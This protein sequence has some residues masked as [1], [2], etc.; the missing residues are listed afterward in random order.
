MMKEREERE[1]EA[2]TCSQC[3]KKGMREC[4]ACKQ[5][6]CENEDCVRRTIAQHEK[7]RKNK[8]KLELIPI[9]GTHGEEPEQDIGVCKTHGKELTMFCKEENVPVCT[10]CLL[11][12]SFSLSLWI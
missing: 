11:I 6:V 4:S 8:H 9:R 1:E 12:G 10:H 7:L 2:V 5:S 3:E